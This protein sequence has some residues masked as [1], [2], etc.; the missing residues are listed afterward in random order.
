MLEMG[1]LHD[2]APSLIGKWIEHF[3][4]NAGSIF[5]KD[6]GNKEKE[7]RLRRYEHVITKLATQNDFLEK[8]LAYA[9]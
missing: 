7:V 5:N 6:N 2:L 4:S 9:K 8:V 1:K 3:V